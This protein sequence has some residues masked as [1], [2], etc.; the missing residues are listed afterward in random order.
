MRAA[1]RK[2]TSRVAE[3][4][5]NFACQLR[6]A[7]VSSAVSK[8]EFSTP[9]FDFQRLAPEWY[10]QWQPRSSISIHFTMGLLRGRE[11]YWTIACML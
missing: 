8:R 10:A 4:P 5:R 1:L 7:A 6:A 9:S 3:C 2:I 11:H